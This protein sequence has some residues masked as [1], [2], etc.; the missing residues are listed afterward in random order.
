M[1]S[2]PAE[3]MSEYTV[4]W[5]GHIERFIRERDSN[6]L[7]LEK[8]IGEWRFDIETPEF[9]WM[10]VTAIDHLGN[11]MDWIVSDSG[12]EDGSSMAR[13]TGLVTVGCIRAWIEDPAMLEAGIHAPESLPRN[14]VISIIEMMREH[15][16]EITGP[17]IN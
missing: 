16:V 15:G 5:P 1:S 3:E 4:R 17:N 7:D 14:V 2:I 9:T 13:T 6:S 10:E 8:L 11:S 12:G